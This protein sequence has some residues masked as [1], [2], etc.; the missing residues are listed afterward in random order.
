MIV[1]YLL[2]KL[3]TLLQRAKRVREPQGY[4]I[5]EKYYYLLLMLILSM[6]F[7]AI[8]GFLVALSKRKKY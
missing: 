4:K 7:D 6:L 8:E 1:C 3:T 5:K 2:T